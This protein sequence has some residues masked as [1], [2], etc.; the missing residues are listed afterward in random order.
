MKELPLLPVS[1]LSGALGVLSI[2]T[3]LALL[4]RSRETLR[5]LARDV[6]EFRFKGVFVKIQ[7]M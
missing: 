5:C 3:K 2:A 6:H 7:N 1:Y 4:G